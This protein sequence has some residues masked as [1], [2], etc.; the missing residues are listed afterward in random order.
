VANVQ[1]E[2]DFA[3]WGNAYVG[4]SEPGIVMVSVDVNG[5]GLPDDEWYELSGS[6]DTDSIGKV[7]YD[8]QVTYTKTPM[9]DVPWQ[10]NKGKSGVVA[11]NDFHQ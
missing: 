6:A 3:I 2:R 9:Q 11:R 4:N 10:D 5:N 8:Y 7:V 1:G